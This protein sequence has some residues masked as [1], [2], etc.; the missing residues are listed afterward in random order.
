[1][2][3][4]YGRQLNKSE[5]LFAEKAAETFGIALDTARL[6]IC[7][8][9][10]TEEKI[11]RFLSP[12]KKEFNDPF[13]LS[14]MSDAVAR[15]A[16]SR[17]SGER[18][19]VFGDY[20]A[21]G[22]CATAILFSAL[23]KFGVNAD[24]IIPERDNGY[25][26]NLSLVAEKEKEGHV[27]LLITVD[28]GISDAE[29]VKE[30]I[31]YGTDV[32]VTDHHE[33]PEILP[34]CIKINPKLSGQD[35]PF[36]GLCGAGVAYK[37]A[38]ALIGANADEYLDLAALA[39][40]ADSMELIEENR[41]IVAEGLKLI[42]SSR[43]RTAIKNLLGKAGNV[44]AQTLAFQ[45][46][47]RLN[48][49]GRMGDANTALTAFTSE[50]ENEIFDS[51]AR[52]TAYNVQRQAECDEI[53]REAKEMIKRENSC[54]DPVILVAS[55]KWRTGFIGIVAARI[56][57]EFSRPVIV[58]AGADCGYKGS[59]RSVASVNIFDALT[60]VKSLLVEFG[61]H[62]QAAGVA[63][64]KENYEPLRRALC[65]YVKENGLLA[66][67]TKAIYAE[68]NIEGK[69]DLGFARDLERLEPF[70]V[71]N[72]RPIFTAEAE[73]TVLSRPL[74]K[75]SPHYSFVIPAGEMLDFYG[76][77]N[78]ETLAL[79]VKKK[80]AFE[81]NYSVFNGRASAKG[82][83]KGVFPDY[84]DGE[85]LLPYVVKNELVKIKNSAP[86]PSESFSAKPLAKGMGTL[87][88]VS[89]AE[90]LKYYGYGKDTEEEN[91]FGRPEVYY[92]RPPEKS[93][94]D[95]VVVSLKE[96]CG[97]HAEIV[98]L[99]KPL[100]VKD[101]GIP[102]SING[103]INGFSRYV[104]NMSTERQ[105]FASVFSYLLSLNG[106]P[107]YGSAEGYAVYSPDFTA[108]Q[109]VFCTEVFFELGI[110]VIENGR[111]IYDARVKNALDN[112]EIYKA[113]VKAGNL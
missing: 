18:V 10:D 58:F 41:S 67:V 86:L 89:D 105:M 45:V 72:R 8:G 112:S 22:I 76:G 91:S 90:N 28:C 16:E 59:A 101:F 62:A 77:G 82:F 99:D 35:Y 102:A 38:R 51:C 87:Y 66:G 15:I 70:G 33:P 19:L 2:K 25:G 27:G 107:F 110:F 73:E 12:G 71:G 47:P 85:S 11:K 36:N 29:K 17:N 30:L 3:I 39:T 104:K 55:E 13:L 103:E 43:T 69:I 97:E 108:E 14:G 80:V 63:V 96:A 64:T 48:A 68:W 23:K 61:G 20:D 46:A 1:M 74:K 52:L 31:A 78:A 95:C 26:L 100:A 50:N 83:V 44:T 94:E 5:I 106:K 42:N 75:G 21:D 65:K 79:P 34:E 60:E 92:F 54:F 109:F 84:A 49:G 57:E 4:V 7:R 88:A 6:L 93:S 98:Y 32:I 81:L 56:A 24:R 53:Y 111:I 9:Y 37:L 40:V 113:V